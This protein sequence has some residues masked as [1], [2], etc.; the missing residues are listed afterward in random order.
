M[1]LL[2]AIFSLFI[3]FLYLLFSFKIAERHHSKNVLALVSS[4]RVNIQ[5]CQGTVVNRTLKLAVS[6]VKCR[7]PIADTS[8]IRGIPRRTRRDWISRE[9]HPVTKLGRNAILYT[10]SEK[11]LHQRI[12]RLQHVDFGLIKSRSQVCCRSKRGTQHTQSVGR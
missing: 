4:H 7:T 8:R 12:V 3:I 6:V 9:R 1:L 2:I 10:V 5:M 11:Q